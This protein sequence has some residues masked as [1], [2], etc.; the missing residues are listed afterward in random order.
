MKRIAD[1]P[2]WIIGSFGLIVAVWQAMEFLKAKDPQSGIPDLMAGT[3]H[4]LWAVLAAIITVV[5]IV[6]YFVRHP[7]VEE[8]IHISR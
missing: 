3:T 5:C 6:A 2:I 7:R 8:E 1:L 4:L